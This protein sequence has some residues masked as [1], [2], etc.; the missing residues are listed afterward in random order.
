MAWP[1]AIRCLLVSTDRGAVYC[2]EPAAVVASRTPTAIPPAASVPTQGSCDAAA[3]AILQ[4]TGTTEGYCLDLGCGTGELAL[5]LALRSTLRIVAVD[6]DAEN[7]PP[8][9]ELL[10]AAGLYGT[11]VVVQQRD[12]A[13]TGYPAYF[14]DLIVSRRALDADL[15]PRCETEAARLLRP[16]GGIRCAGTTE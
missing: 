4:R 13:T 12:L 15:D 3:D 16:Y 10:S 11:R 6:P 8:R 7:V 2:F 9:R 14:A 1:C 5:A